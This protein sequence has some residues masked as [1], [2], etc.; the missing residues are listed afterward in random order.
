LNAIGPRDTTV[1]NLKLARKMLVLSAILMGSMLAVA[2]VAVNRLSEVNAQI[3]QLVDRTALKREVLSDLQSK[4]LQ[5]IRAQKNAILA[6]D[7]ERSKE[8]TAASRST[9]ADARAALDKLKDLT[10]SDRVEGQAAAV[11][12]LGKALDANLKVNNDTLDL[13]VQNTNVKA[14]KLLKGDLQRQTNIL[15]A[16]LGKWAGGVTSKTNPGAADLARLKSLF[17]AHSALLEMY[18]ILSRHIESSSKEEMATEEK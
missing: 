4:L 12:A 15:A 8:H 14:K 1:K 10:A 9:M 17:E 16:L 2:Y 6:P 13:A 7:D 11:E 3:R 5:S 18:S